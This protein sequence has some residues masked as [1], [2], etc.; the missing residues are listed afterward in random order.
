MAK[1]INRTP[2]VKD[3]PAEPEEKDIFQALGL[4]QDPEAVAKAKEAEANEPK[5]ADLLKQLQDMEARLKHT[6]EANLALTQTTQVSPA[7]KEPPAVSY[8]GMPDPVVDAE[9]YGKELHR[10][11]AANLEAVAAYNRDLQRSQ[12]GTSDRYEQLWEDFAAQYP[13]AAEDEDTIEVIAASVVKKAQRR[14]IDPERYMFGN[15]VKFLA[16]VAGEYERIYGPKEKPEG[17]VTSTPKGVDDEDDPGRTGGIFGGSESGGAPAPA[18]P[19]KSD[20]IKD[21]QDMQRRTGFW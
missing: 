1:A 3:K 7:V 2:K 8:E 19:G 15:R 20:M 4:P 16:D 9:G 21:I 14:G 5:V 10:R 17:E 13:E 6:E 18:R 12:Q 11:I